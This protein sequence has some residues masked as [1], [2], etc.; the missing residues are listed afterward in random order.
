M[1]FTVFLR[2]FRDILEK[3]TGKMS[4]SS[5]ISNNTHRGRMNIFKLHYSEKSLYCKK[6]KHARAHT[7]THIIVKP[8]VPSLHREPKR[9]WL[10]HAFSSLHT[11]YFIA[12]YITVSILQAIL[13]AAQMWLVD[14]VVGLLLAA[15]N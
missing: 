7:H 12:Y 5:N 15:G 10:A 9:I 14:I 3:C 4:W 2:V 1:Y 8:I 11:R 6:E 13:H